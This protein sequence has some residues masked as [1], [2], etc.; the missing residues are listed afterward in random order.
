[1][2]KITTVVI[3]IFLLCF[4]AF[5]SVSEAH[6]IRITTDVSTVIPAFQF[7]FSSG[8]LDSSSPVVFNKEAKQFGQED[9]D[10]YGT[11]STLVEVADISLN[12]LDLLFVAK[13][14]NTA[15]CNNSY[16][17]KFMAG[18]FD[19]LRN[20]ERGKHN[21]REVAISINED[22][23]SMGGLSVVQ[24]A[25]DTV[26]VT[27]TGEDCQIGDLA[28]FAVSYDPDPSIDPSEL[29][30]FYYADISLEI[31]SDN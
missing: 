13:L 31:S 2:K 24:I 10:E 18:G 20:G 30:Q 4:A 8:M 19:V 15:K 28:S 5:A 6:T 7:M 9:F 29:D 26:R 3:S 16:T 17:L 11:D 23:A 1:L 14:A 12:K 22:I 21:P 27:F 25:D